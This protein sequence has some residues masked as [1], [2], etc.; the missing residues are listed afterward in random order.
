MFV[1]I[2]LFGSIHATC[3]MIRQPQGPRSDEATGGA[4]SAVSTETGRRP[5]P[6]DFGPYS[7]SPCCRTPSSPWTSDLP[8][9]RDPLI[10]I[11][12]IRIA[13]GKQD[14]FPQHLPSAF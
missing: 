10:K 14:Y 9:L 13:K 5:L 1:D 8:I 2:H 11:T 7:V 6:W 3:F 12:N 4:S